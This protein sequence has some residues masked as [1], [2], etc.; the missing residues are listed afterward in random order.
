MPFAFCSNLFPTF[1]ILLVEEKHEITAAFKVPFIYLYLF[2]YSAG[3]GSSLIQI[4][5][6]SFPDHS[7]LK[8]D[9]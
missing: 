5:Y 2:T 9:P 3:D 8:L 6:Q 4:S 1:V 7:Y